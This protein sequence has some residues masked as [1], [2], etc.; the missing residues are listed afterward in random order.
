MDGPWII[1]YQTNEYNR[2]LWLNCIFLAS[3]WKLTNIKI[4]WDFCS[5]FLVSL[6]LLLACRFY[7]FSAL[8]ID[9]VL[10]F[11][12]LC[13]VTNAC[14]LSTERAIIWVNEWRCLNWHS[15]MCVLFYQMQR[16][17]LKIWSGIWKQCWCLNQGTRALPQSALVGIVFCVIS[18]KSILFANNWSSFVHFPFTCVVFIFHITFFSWLFCKCK[19]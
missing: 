4:S 16:C 17:P 7:L 5:L 11:L 3:L 13:N 9:I 10:V 19:F 2:A 6:W 18:W 14:W 15:V 12:S 8:Y 1:S